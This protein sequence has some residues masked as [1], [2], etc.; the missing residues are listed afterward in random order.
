MA[1]R[2]SMICF[3]RE[4]DRRA[5]RHVCRHELMSPR[6]LI[7]TRRPHLKVCFRRIKTSR[8]GAFPLRELLGER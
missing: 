4:Q 7:C 2:V 8:T 6:R 3:P 5:I 1:C